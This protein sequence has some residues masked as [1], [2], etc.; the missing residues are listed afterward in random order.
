MIIQCEELELE[1]SDKTLAEEEIEVG[2]LYVGKRNQGWKLGTFAYKSLEG[3]V[4]DS[5]PV[6]IYPFNDGECRR[7]IELA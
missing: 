1:V 3:Y 7:V 5:G 4:Y 2:G 6:P